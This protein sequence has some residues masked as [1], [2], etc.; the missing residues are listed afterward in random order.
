MPAIPLIGRPAPAVVTAR[1]LLRPAEV[2]DASGVLAYIADNRE[3]LA[4]WEP[5][6]TAGYYTRASIDD[7][8]RWEARERDGGGCNRFYLYPTDAPDRIIGMVNL[9]NFVH[10]AS[11]RCTVGYA[12]AERAQGRGFMTE[13]L[14]GVVAHCF[15]KLQLH[16]VEAAY[17]PRNE[18]SAAVLRRV[19]F[20]VEG[21]ARDYL[22]IDGRWEDHILTAITNPSWSSDGR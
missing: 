19:G 2:A 1:L 21:F 13:A 15:D 11:L 10:G 18:R 7:L 16:R 6:R 22:L 14:R 20:S 17:L 3:F 4:P 12:L 5:R 8:I 9:A